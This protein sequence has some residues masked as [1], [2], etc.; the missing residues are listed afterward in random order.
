LAISNPIF[1]S[2]N[3]NIFLLMF[4]LDVLGVIILL[5]MIC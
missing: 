1:S 5:I 4:M 2:F 3:K